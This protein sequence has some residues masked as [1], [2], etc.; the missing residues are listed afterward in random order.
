[1]SFSGMRFE[2]SY[3]NQECDVIHE[4]LNPALKQA[5]E[6]DRAV[7]FF[8]STALMAVSIGIENLVKN[9]GRIKI[10]LY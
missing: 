10:R 3:N 2:L 1:M 5:V 8:S 6:Y 4:F 7:G 9:G